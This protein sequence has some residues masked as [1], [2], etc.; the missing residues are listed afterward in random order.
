MAVQ[1]QYS[2]MSSLKDS[3]ISPGYRRRLFIKS[4]K[5]A[6]TSPSAKNRTPLT[7]CRPFCRPGSLSAN[8]G[9]PSR[10]TFSISNSSCPTN[11]PC[12]LEPLFPQPEVNSPAIP[13]TMHFQGWTLLHFQGWPSPTV[14]FLCSQS[15]CSSKGVLSVVHPGYFCTSHPSTYTSLS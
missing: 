3:F 15:L 13:D 5:I 7:P 9:T 14:S 10:R 1:G 6:D 4:L 2:W 11:Q 8:N 12:F